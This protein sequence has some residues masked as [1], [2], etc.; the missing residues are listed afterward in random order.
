MKFARIITLISMAAAMSMAPVATAHAEERTC[1]GRIGVRTVD[2]LRVPSGATCTLEGTTVKG[3][4]KVERGATLYARNVRVIG[5]IQAENAQR[6]NV[7][8]GSRV[9]GNIQVVQGRAGVIRNTVVNADILFDDQSGAIRV[10]RNNVGG[11]I[12]AFQNTGGVTIR[13]N[14]AD[15][16]LQCKENSPRPT[17]GNNTIHGNKEDQCRNL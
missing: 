9:G 13:G 5:N 12:Q 1:R 16:N 15:G 8:A 6:V 3:T 4:A 17:G 2:N 11:N 14:T 10:R 7:V